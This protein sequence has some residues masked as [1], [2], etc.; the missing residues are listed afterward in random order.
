[1]VLS[2]DAGK[3]KKKNKKKKVETVENPP[4][5]NGDTL[6]RS[7]LKQKSKTLTDFNFRRK[8]SVTEE[9]KFDLDNIENSSF[10]RKPSSFRKRINS[11]IQNSP[12]L[13]KANILKHSPS[14]RHD[15]DRLSDSLESLK[16]DENKVIET[17]PIVEEAGLKTRTLDQFKISLSSLY[18]EGG[19]CSKCVSRENSFKSS[20][21]SLSFKNGSLLSLRSCSGEESRKNGRGIIR[22]S[23]SLQAAKKQWPWLLVRFFFFFLTAFKRMM[24]M[25]HALI[26]LM[27]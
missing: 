16:I 9:P 6:Q 4:A 10:E 5:Q 25:I 19:K 13:K 27:D 23:F 2:N 7:W 8:S 1:M 21:S 17:K 18:E 20:Q 12:F 3:K 26:R 15:I 24:V 22:R 14:L 11:F